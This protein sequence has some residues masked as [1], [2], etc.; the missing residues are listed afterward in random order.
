MITIK[1]PNGEV[2]THI[3]GGLTDYATPCGLALDGDQD[4]GRRIPTP[5]GA[6]IDCPSCKQLFALI[7]C[8]ERRDFK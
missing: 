3:D 2:F 5:K 7:K 8:Y 1:G 6:K 4:S